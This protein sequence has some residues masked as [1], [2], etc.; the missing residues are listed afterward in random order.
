MKNCKSCGSEIAL[1]AKRCP[2]CGHRESNKAINPLL[3][4]LTILF[5]SYYTFK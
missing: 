1:N 5:I 2:K 4:I 3:I